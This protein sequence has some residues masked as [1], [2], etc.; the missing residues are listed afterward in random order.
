MGASVSPLSPEVVELH[1][2][3]SHI[4]KHITRL[5]ETA[6]AYVASEIDSWVANHGWSVAVGT[7]VAIALGAYIL[8]HAFSAILEVM[9]KLA[10]KMLA[11]C[12]PAYF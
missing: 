12:F 3:M 6:T 10:L 5:D 2:V 8:M 11:Y 7:L 9:I 4:E 1:E